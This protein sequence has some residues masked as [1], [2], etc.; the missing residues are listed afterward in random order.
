MHDNLIKLAREVLGEYVS[1][2]R[3]DEI[4][5]ERDGNGHVCSV[6]L[7]ER[8]RPV[9]RILD[10]GNSF[11]IDAT[12]INLS[13]EERSAYFVSAKLARANIDVIAHELKEVQEGYVKRADDEYN[14]YL[15]IPV[16]LAPIP[17]TPVEEEPKA[18]EKSA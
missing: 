9:A 17:E 16:E 15:G 6:H 8:R 4:G 2:C 14:P 7:D 18:E 5:Q 13:A 10:K 1:Y 3:L 11:N 12:A